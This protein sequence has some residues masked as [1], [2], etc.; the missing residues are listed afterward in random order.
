MPSIP[1]S[2][3]LSRSQILF[4]N[5]FHDAPRHTIRIQRRTL[6]EGIPKLRL[7]TINKITKRNAGTVNY[8]SEIIEGCPKIRLFRESAVLRG[9]MK[10]SALLHLHS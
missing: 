7:G 9:G 10:N 5:A 3:I 8:F 2:Q 6:L 1:R 4:G